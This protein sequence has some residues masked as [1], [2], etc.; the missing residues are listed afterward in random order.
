MLDFIFGLILYRFLLKFL[1]LL[2]CKTWCG[3]AANCHRVLWCYCHCRCL[4]NILHICLHFLSSF[5]SNFRLCSKLPSHLRFCPRRGK[6][7]V[8][9][10]LSLR[11]CCRFC[12]RLCRSLWLP[13]PRLCLAF[14]DRFLH[15][16]RLSLSDLPP[17]LRCYFLPAVGYVRSCLA[18]GWLCSCVACG[19]LCSFGSFDF[20]L[21][22]G[23]LFSRSLYPCCFISSHHWIFGCGSVNDSSRVTLWL[24]RASW[25]PRLAPPTPLRGNVPLRGR[26]FAVDARAPWSCS[27]QQRVLLTMRTGFSRA[28]ATL[29]MKVFTAASMVSNTTVWSAPRRDAL[30][31]PTPLAGH[32]STCLNVCL[33]GNRPLRLRV[34]F[35]TLLSCS[36]RGRH[37]VS[38]FC[39]DFV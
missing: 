19:W 3:C 8:G 9:F 15:G 39:R 34:L 11:P 29:I 16:V 32:R 4:R 31:R 22:L 35:L 14:G 20:P 33:S 17:D 1:L 23:M 21:L 2:C 26:W 18:C 24:F 36:A 30:V 25:I 6:V 28:V 37:H 12:L 27:L 10:R 5:V 7:W 38:E 13:F